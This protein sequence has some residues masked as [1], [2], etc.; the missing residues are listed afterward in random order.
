MQKFMEDVKYDVSPDPLIVQ[1]DSVDLNINGQF[2]P[3]YFHKK[4]MV[5]AHAYFGL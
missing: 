2:P 3:K 4:A 5:E 1:G